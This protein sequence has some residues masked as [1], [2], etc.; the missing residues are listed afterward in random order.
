MEQPSK[1]AILV[2]ITTVPQSMWKLLDGQLKFM[3][4]YYQVYAVSSPGK[5]LE[6]V[7]EMQKVSVFQIPMERG[8]SPLKDFISLWKIYR[9]IR[10][11]KPDFV[12]SHTPKAGLLSMVASKIAGVK[13]RLHTVAGMPLEVTTGLKRWIL[14]RMEQL[15]YSCATAVYP[16]SNGLFRFIESNGLTSM[17][18]VKIIGNGS[19]NGINTDYFNANIAGLTDSARSLRR[20]ILD[21]D[22]YFTFGFAGRITEDKG[23]NELIEAFLT[24]K[25]EHPTAHLLV[26]GKIE[27]KGNPILTKYMNHIMNDTNIHYLG[28]QKD[29]RPFL[30]ASDIFLFPSY[31]E[32]LPNV[33]LQALSLERPTIATDVTGN[34]DIIEDG[35]N[36]LLIEVKSSS[37]LL[38]SMTRLYNDSELRGFL[39]KGARS[40]ILSKYSQ[41][42]VWKSLLKEYNDQIMTTN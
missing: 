25:V 27:L 5:E 18:K 22:K 35:V 37:S 32:G 29:I 26:A 30:M 40:S 41:D 20:S 11:V 39:S 28:Y 6:W 8:I 12:H 10:K 2:R 23:V 34:S 4:Q 16:N 42:F 14:L 3:N 9:F 24:F 17:N 19:S 7:Q 21:S 33:L 1:K 38:E 36:G 15:T 31:R 13:I